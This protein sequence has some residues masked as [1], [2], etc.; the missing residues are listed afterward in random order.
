MLKR[1]SHSIENSFSIMR[2]EV[3][4]GIASGKTTFAG[5]MRRVDLHTLFENF[6][7]NPF[8]RAFYSNPGKYIFETEVSFTL[9]HYHQIKKEAALDKI[10]ICDFSLLLDVAYAEIGLQGTQLNTYLKVYEEIKRELPLPILL[11]HLE[12][13]AETEMKRIRAR[14]RA[15]EKSI[16]IEF[17]DSLNKAVDRQ[18]HLSKGKQNIITIDSSKNNFADDEL[19]KQEMTALMTA[20][21]GQ[22]KENDR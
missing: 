7:A 12:C 6:R 8:W 10:N 19:V 17:L 22:L 2:I 3:C 18:V 14:A 9:Q 13:D 5:L 1:G 16:T 11:V 21:L 4:G 15:V 20:T